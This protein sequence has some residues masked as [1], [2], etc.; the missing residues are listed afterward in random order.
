MKVKSLLKYC[1][2]VNGITFSPKFI[3]DSK[4]ENK[5]FWKI[6]YS[7]TFCN[8]LALDINLKSEGVFQTLKSSE[9]VKSRG[10]HWV[11]NENSFPQKILD[12]TLE[13]NSQNKQ[14]RFLYGMFYSWFFAIFFEKTSKFGFWVDGW[15]LVIKAKHFRVFLEIF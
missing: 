5:D 3:F 13:T 2:A 11:R 4:V 9:N 14:N 10:L 7:G 15:L 8:G 12:K 6:S 1:P